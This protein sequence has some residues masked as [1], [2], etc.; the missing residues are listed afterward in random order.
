MQGWGLVSWGWMWIMLVLVLAGFIRVVAV[1]T[2]V[3]P[4]AGS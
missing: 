1:D 2:D 4:S 3:C